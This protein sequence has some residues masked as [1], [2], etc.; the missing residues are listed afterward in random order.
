[1]AVWASQRSG[2]WSRT[3]DNADSPW[4]DGGAQTA[5]AAI[6]ANTD[7]VTI[8]NTHDVEFDTDQSLFAAGITLTVA[9]GGTLHASTTAGAYV[10]KL[11][12]TDMT[13]AGTL[14]AGTSAAVPYPSTC[15]F[16][17]DHSNNAKSIEVA[18]TGHN[19][20]YCTQPTNPYC[21]TTGAEAAGQ[22]E[23]GV[24]TDLS[25]DGPWNIASA[26]VRIVDSTPLDSEVRTLANTDTN[27]IDVTAGITNPKS[28]ASMVLLVTRNVRIINVAASDYAITYAAGAGGGDYIAAEINNCYRAIDGGTGVTFAGTCELLTTSPVAINTSTALT[29]A[30]WIPGT[31]AGTA[32]ALS[33]CDNAIVTGVIAGQGYGIYVANNF[34]LRGKVFGCSQG[35]INCMGGVVAAV[36]SVDHCTYGI[37]NSSAITIYGTLGPNAN[38]SING[39]S[40]IVMAGTLG[41]DMTANLINVEDSKFYDTVFGSGTEFSG[42]NGNTRKKSGYVESIDH[43]G[44]LNAY[45]AWCRGG[46]V[47]SQTAS[48]PTGYTIWYE[49]AAEDVTQAYPVFRQYE[50]TVPAGQTLEVTGYLRI[51]D[52]EDLSAA[53]LVPALQI[54]DKFADPLVDSTQTT[55]DSCEIPIADGSEAGWQA[56]DVLWANAGA[57]PRQVIVRM[58]AYNDGG[59]DTVDVDGVWAVADYQDQ[60]AAIYAKLPTNYLM[61]ASDQDNH[62]TDIDAILADTGTDGVKIAD[63]AITAAKFDESTA[64]PVKSADTGAT[65][66]ARTGA[67]SDTLETLSDQVDAV[68]PASSA[69]D[70]STW[71]DARAGK[72]DNL[73]AAVSTRS[74]HSPSDVKTAIEAAGGSIAGIATACTET[75]LAELDA[76]NLPTDV[77]QVKSDTAAI[78]TDTG[79]AGVIVAVNNDK[80]GYALATGPVAPTAGPIEENR[81]RARR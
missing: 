56:V 31:S 42:Y 63:D 2:L 71:T 72:L 80:T 13:Q 60:I 58:I 65:T 46:I 16:T 50:T 10:L 51:A 40:G 22:T 57:A 66:I 30:G 23:I 70:K 41:A 7:S 67:D 20:I 74:S 32:I 64:F 6:P 25:G 77:A 44:T 78:L 48:P 43:D 68:A 3:S 5:L 34:D 45:K 69:L 54:I 75:R 21:Y 4:H 9:A 26:Q 61:G 79:T 12:N 24:D 27:H 29:M 14:R 39:C 33:S 62:D 73:N 1:M 47:T 55:L 28:T 59:A 52:G 35:M 37:Q 8:A 19:Y 15:T 18:A 38:Y 11:Q 17:I 49:L 81:G 53:G 36:A 76:D